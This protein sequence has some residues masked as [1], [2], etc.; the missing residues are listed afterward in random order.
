MKKKEIIGIIIA[1]MLSLSACGGI[2][3]TAKVDKTAPNSA[4]AEAESTTDNSVAS[5]NDGDASTGA[6]D[7]DSNSSGASQTAGIKDEALL[8]Q[9]AKNGYGN[10]EGNYSVEGDFDKDGNNE[11]IAFLTDDFVED[12]NAYNGTFYFL[13]K[14]KCEILVDSACIRL[15]EDKMFKTYDV[16]DKV[17]I[18]ADEAYVTESVSRVFYVENGECKNSSVSFIGDFYEPKNLDDYCIS[19]GAYDMTCDYEEGKE[20]L[21]MYT[22]HTWKPYYFY[23]DKESGDF[24]EYVAHSITEEELNSSCGFDLA[25]DI[26]NEGYEVDSIMKR[27]NGIITVNYSKKEVD[28]VNVCAKFHNANFDENKHEFL[29]VYDYGDKDWMNSDFDGIY[30][31]S[32]TV[33]RD[34]N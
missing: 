13:T 18:C 11:A 22:G 27:D 24:K 19:V 15:S 14:D 2:M 34:S 30:L 16:G 9:L 25:A 28:G 1:C 3:P 17:F 32:I 4:F 23:Y 8:E 6:S 12:F 26:R 5:E 21:A 31:E 7:G 33:S 10:L 20:A 29:Y